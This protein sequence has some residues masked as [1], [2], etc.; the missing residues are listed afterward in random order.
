[1]GSTWLNHQVANQQII[2]WWTLF[3]WLG[4]FKK[5]FRTELLRREWERSQG[6]WGATIPINKSNTLLMMSSCSS[7]RICLLYIKN[8]YQ[9][10][11]WGSRVAPKKAPLWPFSPFFW[12]R[13]RRL[14]WNLDPELIQKS[15]IT[16]CATRG[17]EGLLLSWSQKSDPWWLL[18][19]DLNALF[20]SK[21]CTCGKFDVGPE[22]RR[23]VVFLGEKTMI[24]Q[25]ELLNFRGVDDGSLVFEVTLFPEKKISTFLLNGFNCAQCWDSAFFENFKKKNKKIPSSPRTMFSRNFWGHVASLR[26]FVPPAPLH[27]VY[28]MQARPRART[29]PVTELGWFH[30]P[31]YPGIWWTISWSL[32]IIRWFIAEN[33]WVNPIFCIK[34]QSILC[35]IYQN[36][37]LRSSSRKL[38]KKKHRFFTLK[39]QPPVGPKIPLSFWEKLRLT[40][41]S[42]ST[43]SWQSLLIH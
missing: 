22:L 18:G 3:S 4:V 32:K 37:D 20:P 36:L 43:G 41:A 42:I 7:H 23:K 29:D 15:I 38:A 34:L 24:F 30:H 8:I 11:R 5:L 21:T 31:W 2:H 6:A 26:A 19:G 9:H 28:P 13:V 14:R 35:C 16:T 40:M 1:M 39:N 27:G 25:R 10:L 33:F 17:D 12:H